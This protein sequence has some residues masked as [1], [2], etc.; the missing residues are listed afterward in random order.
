MLA[1]NSTRAGKEKKKSKLR[2]T[3]VGWGK[4]K[5]LKKNNKTHV[6]ETALNNWSKTLRDGE[7]L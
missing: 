3:R 1:S 7:C 4:E 5:K 2:V 6:I